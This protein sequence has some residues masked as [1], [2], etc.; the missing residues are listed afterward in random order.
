MPQCTPTQHNNKKERKKIKL[1]GLSGIPVYLS[2][3]AFALHVGGPTFHPQYHKKKK[4]VNIIN[5]AAIKIP[6]DTS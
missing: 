1:S 3:R 5:S 2:D 6:I 4:K